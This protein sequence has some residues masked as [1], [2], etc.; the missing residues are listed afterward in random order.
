[1]QPARYEKKGAKSAWLGYDDVCAGWLGPLATAA[2]SLRSRP[3]GLD[4]L[5]GETSGD[6]PYPVGS[7]DVVSHARLEEIEEKGSGTWPHPVGF[8]D[9]LS[10]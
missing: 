4:V 5:A 3:L 2:A 9:I 10:T 1:M 7:G 8:V 6:L